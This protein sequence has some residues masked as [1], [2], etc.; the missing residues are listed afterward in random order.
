M[1][2]F[3]R[4]KLKNALPRCG[5]TGKRLFKSPGAAMQFVDALGSELR[6]EKMRPYQCPFCSGYHLTSQD[7][8]FWRARDER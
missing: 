2:K 7:K 6:A 5:A 1:S 3:D 8:G 4:R